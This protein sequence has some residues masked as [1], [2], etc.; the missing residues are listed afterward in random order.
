MK[1][2]PTSIKVKQK[3]IKQQTREILNKTL[4]EILKQKSNIK[5]QKPKC[6]FLNPIIF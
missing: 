3:L 5:N 2:K 4:T 6:Y 1:Q